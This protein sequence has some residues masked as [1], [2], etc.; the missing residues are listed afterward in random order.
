[1]II[2]DYKTQ[3]VYEP[4]FFFYKDILLLILCTGRCLI[5]PLG[6]S[7]LSQK[8]LFTKMDNP[9]SL[10]G[11]VIL[12]PLFLCNPR[13]NYDICTLHSAGCTEYSFTKEDSHMSSAIQVG[14]VEL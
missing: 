8:S 6:C 5:I 13:R 7:M 11:L 12:F 9:C 14:V 4:F 2:F 10:L 3:N 1:M